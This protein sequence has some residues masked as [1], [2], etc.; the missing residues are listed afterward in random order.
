MK[1]V[2]ENVLSSE[3]PVISDKEVILGGLNTWMQHSLSAVEVIDPTSGEHFF[4]LTNHF[5]LLAEEIAEIYR[6]RWQIE[7]FFK[8]I[9]QHL[10]I[11]KFYGACYNAV[12]NQFYAALILFLLLKLM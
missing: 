8:W 9:K 10:K 7:I 1:L 4:I 5:D 11:K 12:L 6:L 2:N 3:S